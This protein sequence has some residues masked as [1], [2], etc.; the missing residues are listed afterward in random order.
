MDNPIQRFWRDGHMGMV[1]AIHVPGAV[2]HVSA[3]GQLD[4]VPPPGP[5]RA[6]I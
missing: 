6:M 1:H 2:F 3:L 4:S 5:L